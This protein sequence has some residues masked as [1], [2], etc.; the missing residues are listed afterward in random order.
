M[1]KS[2]GSKRDHRFWSRMPFWAILYMAIVVCVAVGAS[3]YDARSGESPTYIACD[4]LAAVGLV[5]MVLAYWHGPTALWL[6]RGTLPLVLLVLGWEVYA[7]A[8]ARASAPPV[9]ERKQWLWVVLAALFYAPA[10][11]AGAAVAVRAW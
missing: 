11:A 1:R 10:F 4:V 7:T 5:L 2:L 6:G 8:K 3:I 9:S